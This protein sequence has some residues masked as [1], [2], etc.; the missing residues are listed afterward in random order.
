M[1][2]GSTVLPMR[3]S[4]PMSRQMPAF[5]R[6]VAGS[7]L[8]FTGDFV[9]TTPE[10]SYDKFLVPLF[11]HG[12]SY[13]W[14]A[15]LACAG[16]LHNMIMTQTASAQAS[17]DVFDENEGRKISKYNRRPFT[18]RDSSS[19]TFGM[20]LSFIENSR[21]GTGPVFGRWPGASRSNGKAMIK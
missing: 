10:F 9:Q 15:P 20:L 2:A 5:T 3:P 14:V 16:R 19:I 13:G 7:E 1:T 4:M 18:I 6:L 11:L 17:E 12:R 8:G 21:I